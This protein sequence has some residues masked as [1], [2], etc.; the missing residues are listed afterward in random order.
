MRRETV[1]K[2]HT[3]FTDTYFLHINSD[4][5]IEIVSL[6]GYGFLLIP[7]DSVAPIF[8]YVSIL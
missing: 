6:V 2:T 8:A 4:Q 1:K 7:T 3:F 5:D